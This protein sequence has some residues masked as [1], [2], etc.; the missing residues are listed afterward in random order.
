MFK[1]FLIS[2]C[3]ALAYGCLLQE[4]FP[5]YLKTIWA[6]PV[7]VL[8]G[9]SVIFI[10]L[11]DIK[12]GFASPGSGGAWIYRSKNPRLFWTYIGGLYVMGAMMTI[13]LPIFVLLDGF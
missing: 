11:R 10:G 13:F 1:F 5:L 3:A 9:V 6:L 7:P 12:R 4:F 8:L 2:F